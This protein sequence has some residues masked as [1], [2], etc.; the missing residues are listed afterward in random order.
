[1]TQI[2]NTVR[3]MVHSLSKGCALSVALCVGLVTGPAAYAQ[4]LYGTL[5]GTVR[6]ASGATVPNAKVEALETSQGAIRIANSD[7]DGSYRI[8]DLV[9]GNYKIT[10]SAPNFA[11]F[12]TDNLPIDANTVQRLDAK[13]GAGT[14]TQTVAVNTAPALLQTE[15]SDV[16]AQ[17]T[18]TQLQNI[19]AISSERK[20]FQALYKLVPG[21][22]MPTENNSA[23]GNPPRA[24][25]SNVN[26]QSSQE[27]NTSIDGVINS[28]P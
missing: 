1:M 16:Q 10:I 5:T 6:D 27:N 14:L 2:G 17:L 22:T 12:I 26:G 21:A 8:T 15:R 20:N 28:Y 9:P 13:L 25:T 7:S 3:R 23:A 24:M 18:Q 11:S 4:I 19:P